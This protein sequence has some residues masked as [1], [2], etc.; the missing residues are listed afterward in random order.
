MKIPKISL[1]IIDTEVYELALRAIKETISR[2]DFSEVLIFS[3][4]P[5]KWPGFSIIEI[6]KIQSFFEY[7]N[8]IINKLHLYVKTD[9][10]IL[11]QYDGYVTDQSRFSNEFFKYDYIGAL[12]P[13]HKDHNVGNGGFSW[14]SRKLMES[15]ASLGYSET[16]K[17]PEDD[18]ICRSK[19][20][21]LEEKFECLFAST[22]VASQF[23]IEH[24]MPTS[25]S[26]GF[27]G[28]WHLVRIY[29]DD[30][31]NLLKHLPPR[32]F[33]SNPHFAFIYQAMKIYAPDKIKNLVN[34]RKKNYSFLNPKKYIYFKR[35]Y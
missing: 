15:V 13:W 19:R 21:I 1:V 9:Y 28:V 16:N 33:K 18:F 4:D 34:L 6:P 11:I 20:T 27:H 5:A 17:E 8:L 23:S 29:K 25:L 2:V 35:Y 14:R 10:L 22:E 26:F 3:D 24:G 12:W 7:N 32:I 31:E 30:I